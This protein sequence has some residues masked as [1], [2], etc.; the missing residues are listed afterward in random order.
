MIRKIK[1]IIVILIGMLIIQGCSVRSNI[2]VN[3]DGSVKEEVY[4]LESN[5]SFGD[6]DSTFKSIIDSKIN[7]HKTAL[8]YKNYR[9]DYEKG[10]DLSGAKIYKN[11]DNL[12]SFFE[13]SGFNQ[14]VYKF[15]ECVENSE[16][17]EIKNKTE[18]IP[19]CPEC[20]DWPAL[21]NV[22]FK[23]ILPVSAYEQN[24]DEI[25]STTY[26]WKYDKN[27]SDKDFYLRV[28]KKDLEEHK[29]K[30]EQKVKNNKKVRNVII[31][32]ALALLVLFVI[33]ISFVLKK[34]YKNNKID[35]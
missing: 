19:Y 22:E 33:F 2:T 14:Y 7:E 26:I 9:Y 3:Y 23:I 32:S 30:Y 1:Y 6:N 17:Y 29:V 4:L 25:D 18:Y 10:N 13:N 11:Y 31:Y 12:C 20:S 35:Y 34:K 16:F 27:T 5:S 8:D 15:M 24:A 21:E 28:N